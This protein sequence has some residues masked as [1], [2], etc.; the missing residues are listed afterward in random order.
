MTSA[1]RAFVIGKGIIV[2]HYR[3]IPPRIGGGLELR[4]WTRFA[5]LVNSSLDWPLPIF[6]RFMWFYLRTV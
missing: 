2:L 5:V 1:P 3:R 6:R 4:G